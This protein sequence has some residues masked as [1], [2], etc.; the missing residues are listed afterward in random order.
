MRGLHPDAIFVNGN[1]LTLDPRNRRAQAVA[2]LHGR[3]VAVGTTREVRALAGPRTR[4][5][6]LE[7]ATVIPGFNDA[8]CHV[9][10]FGLS[11][12]QVGLKEDEL[13]TLEVG[14]WADLCALEA[15]PRAVPPT[16]LGSLRVTLTAVAGEV[17][18]R[19]SA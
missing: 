13:G 12:L 16:E 8:H 6:D 7:G 1:V 2:A 18:H 4:R 14:K 11:L 9:L 15:D 19:G 3:I 17:V 5:H 10:A